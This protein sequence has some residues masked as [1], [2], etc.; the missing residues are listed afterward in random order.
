LRL[1]SLRDLK[2]SLKHTVFREISLSS[3]EADAQGLPPG[4]IADYKEPIPLLSLGV[5]PVG[6]GDY[7]VAVRVQHRGLEGGPHVDHIHRAS[8][9][10]VDV[11]YVGRVVKQSSWYQTKQRPLLIGASAGHIETIGGTIGCFVTPTGGDGSPRILSNNHVLANENRG[12]SGD[13]IVQPNTYDGGTRNDRVG[14]L[15]RFIELARTGANTVDC[16]MATIGP[17]ITVDAGTLTGVGTLAGMKSDFTGVDRVEKIGRTT[18]LTKGR[19]TAFELD[20]VVF[21]YD[22]GNIRF[23]DQ[24]EI[25]GAGAEAFSRPGDSGSLVFTTGTLLALGL[26]VAG[27]ET[28]GSNG[29]GVSYASMLATVLNRLNSQLLA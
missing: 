5:A 8:K 20:D 19:V 9:G 11:R 3:K 15:D 24:I 17:G 16:A 22:I 26:L 18:G 25:E 14:G 13:D 1:E 6:A 7:R 23:D 2:P 21:E 10:E 27:S 12:K 29:Q 4:V 28:G